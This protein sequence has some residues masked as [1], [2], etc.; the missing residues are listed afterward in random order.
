LKKVDL[1]EVKPLLTPMSTTMALDADEDD[2]PV[3][4][5]E[6]RSMTGSPVLDY[7]ETR[8]TLCSVSVCS[9]PG[10][11]HTSHR[12]TVKRIMSYLCF[13]PK[14]SLWYSSSSVLS[15]CGYFDADFARFHLERKS[16]IGHLFSNAM[17]QEQGNAIV[18]D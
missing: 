6:Y 2:K 15:V 17:N 16:T 4:Q 10:F 14:F 18:K 8:C 1:G 11:P 9:F 3:D 7:N 5:K 13:T 12:Q